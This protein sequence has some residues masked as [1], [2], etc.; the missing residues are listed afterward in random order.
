[1]FEQLRSE[2]SGRTRSI[3]LASLAAHGLLLIFLLH[4]PEPMLLTPAFV[5]SGR[6]GKSATRLY[7]S[8][9]FS[10][11]S[12]HSSADE[13][14]Q[15]Y[16]QQRFG[17]AKLT[18]SKPAQ[19]AK[20]DSQPNRISP[21][22]TEDN[23]K[24]QTLSAE[25]HGTQAGALY[26]TLNRSS[27]FGDEIR[28]ALPVRTSDPVVYPWQL[29]DSPGN[30]EIEITIDE[31]GE[32]VEKVVLHSLGAEIDNRCLAALENWHFQPATRNGA[33]IPSKQHTVFPFK[34]RG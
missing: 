17:R 24:T 21:A 6:N 19:S 20:L 32:I 8:S 5:A 18:L 28:P 22:E 29:P 13:A 23:A 31:R 33:P 7:W 1:M 3:L 34:A 30:E 10:D 26:G 11:D 25:G 9:K 2:F 12:S 4:A 16:R 14:T 27:L 15:R